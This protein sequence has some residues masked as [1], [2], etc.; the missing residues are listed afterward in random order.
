MAAEHE[1]NPCSP[2]TSSTRAPVL[3]PSAGEG[4]CVVQQALPLQSTLIS[5]AGLNGHLPLLALHLF[6]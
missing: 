2:I 5:S 4:A 6:H 1:R 3:L